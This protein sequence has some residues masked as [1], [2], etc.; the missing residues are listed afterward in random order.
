MTLKKMICRTIFE[1]T[2]LKND[3]RLKF[4]LNDIYRIKEVAKYG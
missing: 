4:L 1:K 2:A 3:Y